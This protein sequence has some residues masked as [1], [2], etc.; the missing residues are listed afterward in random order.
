[1]S[2]EARKRLFTVDEF[3]RMGEAGILDNEARLELWGESHEMPPVGPIH[4]GD[5]NAAEPLGRF[6][7]SPS[8]THVIVLT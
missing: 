5:I 4:Q 3:H 6:E 8:A 7:R 1:M 2:V